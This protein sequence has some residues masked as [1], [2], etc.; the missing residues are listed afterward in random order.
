MSCQPAAHAVHDRCTQ[1]AARAARLCSP[2]QRVFVHA[3]S[4]L[5]SLLIVLPEVRQGACSL[6]P[7][8]SLALSNPRSWQ[9]GMG[10]RQARQLAGAI[11]SL[12]EATGGAA[13]F[14]FG[15]AFN[16][17]AGIPYFPVGFAGT[18]PGEDGGAD[19]GGSAP[20]RG[21]AIGTENSALLYR[22]FE[23]ATA[24]VAAS[25]GAASVLDAAQVGPAGAA[26]C[27]RC[28]GALSPVCRLS[29]WLECVPP[30]P[31]DS[32][33]ALALDCCCSA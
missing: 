5:S 23:A 28:C 19:G 21:F 18:H 15:V 9:R 12:A 24:E 16:C 6:P 2:S 26:A 11:H 29:C 14:R 33:W 7:E 8:A 10:Q 13:N 25:G 30:V 20:A 1:H 31:P 3:L 17:P 22:A 32:A 27:N 4:S